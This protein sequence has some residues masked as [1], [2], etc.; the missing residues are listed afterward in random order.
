MWVFYSTYWAFCRKC[1]WKRSNIPNFLHTFLQ[2]FS[3]FY[4]FFI[5]F[6]EFILKLLFIQ[7]LLKVMSWSYNI[8]TYKHFDWW[9][10]QFL[11][12]LALI[13]K[14]RDWKKV[15]FWWCLINWSIGNITRCIQLRD[16]FWEPYLLSSCWGLF[17]DLK[18]SKMLYFLNLFLS[19]WI[20]VVL[21]KVYISF[22]FVSISQS[23]WLYIQF[24]F[25]ELWI[26]D[27][28]LM[29]RWLRLIY[30]L[31][32]EEFLGFEVLLRFNWWKL[33]NCI[34]W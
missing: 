27:N 30:W 17:S 6:F 15:V 7:L 10:I 33:W 21:I 25:I 2:F 20:I 8:S 1:A 23:R 13:F 18:F 3:S 34:S 11:Y 9:R 14:L 31:P 32:K 4:L 16:I 29:N 12:W 22:P 24:I 5:F 28:L 19:F 26:L